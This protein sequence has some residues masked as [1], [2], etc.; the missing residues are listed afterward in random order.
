MNAISS[1]SSKTLLNATTNAYPSNRSARA[2]TASACVASSRVDPVLVTDSLEPARAQNRLP[3]PLQP[4]HEQQRSDYDTQRVDRDRVQR[5]PEDRDESGEPSDRRRGAEEWSPPAARRAERE[6][7]RDRLDR[8]HRTRGGYTE[9]EQQ[10]A[11]HRP[12]TVLDHRLNR[13]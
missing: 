3:Q 12:T 9:N 2:S 11:G 4:E 10:I 7:D 1:P 8:F 6:H 5:R 13:T